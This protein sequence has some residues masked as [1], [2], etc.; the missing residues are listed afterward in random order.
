T[1]L[2]LAI[3]C[4]CKVAR[5]PPQ[6]EQRMEPDQSKKNATEMAE[7]LDKSDRANIDVLGGAFHTL[8]HPIKSGAM[9]VAVAAFT[10]PLAVFGNLA[11]NIVRLRLAADR[12]KAMVEDLAKQ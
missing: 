7:M 11:N 3:Q 10:V 1:D 2:K 9:N 4:P 5:G 8:A 6:T 12:R